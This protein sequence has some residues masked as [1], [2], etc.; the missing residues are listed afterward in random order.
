V[1]YECQR[2]N[3]TLNFKFLFSFSAFT[4]RCY[5]C[6]PNFSN[7]SRANTCSNPTDTIDCTDPFYDSCLSLSITG[8][9]GNASDFAEF[10][11]HSFNRTA[12]F[13]CDD[14]K[15]FTCDLLKSKANAP[16]VKLVNCEISCCQGDLCNKPLEGPSAS[17]FPRRI[18]PPS[19][20]GSITINFPLKCAVFGILGVIPLVVLNIF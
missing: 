6:A 11:F 18:T 15:N 16:G 3:K 20:S 12:K 1:P 13:L 8:L 9:R 17:W 4:I 19:R 14:I 10:T 2:R 7:F 5:E